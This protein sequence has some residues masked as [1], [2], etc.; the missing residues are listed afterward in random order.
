MGGFKGHGASPYSLVG[1]KDP[2]FKGL[3]LG[4]RQL[5]GGFWRTSHHVRME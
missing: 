4:M 1:G 5:C 2:C 3:K